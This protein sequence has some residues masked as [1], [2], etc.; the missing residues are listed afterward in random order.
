MFENTPLD[1]MHHHPGHKAEVD[2]AKKAQLKSGSKKAEIYE[3]IESAGSLGATCSEIARKKGWLDSTVRRRVTDLWVEG[4]VRK[5][6]QRTRP[7]D[8]GNEMIVYVVGTDPEA[9]RHT[10]REGLRDRIDELETENSLLRD[11]LKRFEHLLDAND[12]AKSLVK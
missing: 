9:G 10:S 12:P 11:T 6:G 5:D 3:L 4:F 7:N 8:S 1:S 2:N